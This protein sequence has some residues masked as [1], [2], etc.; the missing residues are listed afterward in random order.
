LQTQI[1]LLS[2]IDFPQVLKV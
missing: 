2:V 1:M